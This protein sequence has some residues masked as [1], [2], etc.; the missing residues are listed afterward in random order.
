MVP[1]LCCIS[2]WLI[3]FIHNI[4]YILI[5]SFY[6]F[7]RTHGMCGQRSNPSCSCDLHYS[8]GNDRYLTHCARPSIDPVLLQR[9]YWILN[10]LCQSKNSSLWF[11]FAFSWWL[12]ISSIFFMFLLAICMSSLEKYILRSS[13]NFQSSFF[14]DVE[15]CELSIYFKC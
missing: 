6:F 5:Y 12:T 4:L 13:A 8:C 7:G 2:L 1:S 3:Y 10:L 11:W 9:Q 14:F 15:L